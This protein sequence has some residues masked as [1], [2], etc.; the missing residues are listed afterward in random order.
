[1]FGLAVTDLRWHGQMLA[2]QPTGVVN[3]WT[4]TP[5]KVRLPP[6]SRLGF[7]LK[8][9][10]RKIGGF[11]YV[12]SYQEA[13]I[14]D[15]WMRWGPANGVA[16]RSE[17]RDR[18]R[19]FAR[20]RSK[21]PVDDDHKI[22]CLILED[23]TFLEAA[24]QSTPGVLGLDFPAQIVKWKRFPGE[25]VLPF[26]RLLPTQ[27]DF[28]LVTS[29]ED[30]W[31]LSRRKRR[32]AQS[33]FRRT[34]LAAYERTCAVS[35]ADCLEVLQAA[36]IQPFRSLDSHHVQNGIALRS[37]IHALFD[38]GLIAFEDDGRILLSPRLLGHAYQN[39]AGKKFTLPKDPQAA[40]SPAALRHHREF[41][42]RA[43]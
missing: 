18:I 14:D 9:P 28:S 3:F 21:V 32:L 8:A 30:D 27:A 26:E 42:F 12:Q 15:A 29:S 24:D 6:E 11:G 35:G 41:V 19:E 16:S 37:D 7:M 38:A 1:M 31:A 40:P 33:Q 20:K 43:S 10:V 2:E 25:L 17:L 4:P 5:W 36:H 22:G 23:C 13:S 34:V 39:L